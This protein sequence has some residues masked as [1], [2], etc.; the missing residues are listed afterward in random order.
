MKLKQRKQPKPPA[1]LSAESA[2]FF[3]E[4]IE[5]YQIDDV[6]GLKL[7]ERGCEALDLMRKAQKF[8]RKDGEVI[9]DKKGSVKAHPAVS[10]EKEAHNQFVESLRMLNLDLEPLRDAPGRPPG[11]KKHAN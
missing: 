6:A 1:K 2:R 11:G 8:L 10:I 7:L 3:R 9:S 5:Q 4:M